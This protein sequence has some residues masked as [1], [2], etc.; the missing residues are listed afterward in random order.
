VLLTVEPQRAAV[1]KAFVALLARVGLVP[2]V[3]VVV[4]LQQFKVVE[5]LATTL[6][7]VGKLARMLTPMMLQSLIGLKASATVLTTYT[8]LSLVCPLVY[9]LAVLGGKGFGANH[10]LMGLPVKKMFQLIVFLHTVFALERLF[11]LGTR[12]RRRLLG[13]FRYTR[14]FHRRRCGLL[15]TGGAKIFPPRGFT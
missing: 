5:P 10:A 1:G 6:A 12:H 11:T 14:P 4:L 7:V 15:D 3:Q 13:G 2:G 9:D 8:L